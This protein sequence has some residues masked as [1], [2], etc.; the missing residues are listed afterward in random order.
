MYTFVKIGLQGMVTQSQLKYRK[1]Y[2][3]RSE[4]PKPL[5]LIMGVRN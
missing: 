3:F 1:T 4:L 5:L 2:N